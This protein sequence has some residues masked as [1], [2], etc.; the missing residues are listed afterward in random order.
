[1]IRREEMEQREDAVP[2]ITFYFMAVLCGVGVDST[3]LRMWIVT[4]ILTQG[5]DSESM[6]KA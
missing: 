6:G 5:H 2:H 4:R 1:M 3:M